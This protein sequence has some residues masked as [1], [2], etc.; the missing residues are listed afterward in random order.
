MYV[1]PEV[2]L[3]SE[4]TLS[5]RVKNDMIPLIRGTQASQI[6][7]QKGERSCQGLRGISV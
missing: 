2:I 3:T 6:Q 4:I 1:N 5:Q 7:R